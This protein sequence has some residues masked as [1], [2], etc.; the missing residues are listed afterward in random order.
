MSRGHSD[1]Y[2]PLNDTVGH[3]DGSQ[4]WAQVAVILTG[5]SL[6][7]REPPEGSGTAGGR[8]PAPLHQGQAYSWDPK[9]IQSRTER[10]P[11]RRA[12]FMD[13]ARH[14]ADTHQNEGGGEGVRQVLTKHIPKIQ[15]AIGSSRN[16]E[17]LLCCFYGKRTD[18]KQT[19]VPTLSP[20]TTTEWQICLV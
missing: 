12:Q 7:P 13:P 1:D 19:S 10:C 9:C 2:L 18:K 20:L 11:Y 3:S 17:I 5:S 15:S 14:L 6:L 16:L 4:Q 8:H